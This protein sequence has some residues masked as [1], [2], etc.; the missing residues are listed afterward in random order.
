M[1]KTAL[2]GPKSKKLIFIAKNRYTEFGTNDIMKEIL[3]LTK[4]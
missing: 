1:F 4:T 3:R 2:K